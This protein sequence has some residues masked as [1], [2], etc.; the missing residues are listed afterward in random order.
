MT[1]ERSVVQA[2]GFKKDD[3]VVALDGGNQQ[4]FGIVGI[5]RHDR[6]QAADMGKER[7]GALAVGL[8]AIDAAAAR[9]AY[10]QRRNELAGRAR[11]E[12]RRGGKEWGSTCRY[13]W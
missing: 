2:L 5:G 13:R 9:H 10:G 7:F 8:P 12:A 6:A 4:A 1:I 11:P 3:R